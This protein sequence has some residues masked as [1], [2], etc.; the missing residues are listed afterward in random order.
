VWDS[1]Y[2]SAFAS[3]DSAIPTLVDWILAGT[4]DLSYPDK[5]LLA[6]RW[7]PLAHSEDQI[8]M[9]AEVMVSLAVR[10]PMTRKSASALAVQLRGPLPDREVNMLAASN[11]QHNQRNN[12]RRIANR[13]KF[14]LL[15]SRESEFIFGDGFFHNLIVPNGAPHSP[16][17]VIPFL[18][19][20]ALLHISPM[21]YSTNP[22]LC[23][24]LANPGEVRAINASVKAYAAKELFYRSQRPELCDGFEH[25]DHARYTHPDNPM[26]AMLRTLPGV[27]DRDRSLDS[28]FG[29]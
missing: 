2:E 27:S 11:L 1:S 23:V 5:P 14:G 19:T 12:V 10:S 13:G 17:M 22:R 28:L 18:P 25:K 7:V 4:V 6:D 3:A 20:A 24:A 8:A 29:Y 26:E 21:S 15:L 9:M 16:Q